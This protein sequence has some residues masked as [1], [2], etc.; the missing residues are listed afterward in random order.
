MQSHADGISYREWRAGYEIDTNMTTDGFNILLKVD[1]ETGMINGG[2]PSNCL[3]W[4][5]KMGSSYN[6]GNKGI[7]ATSRS[8]EPVELAGLLK[9]SLDGLVRLYEQG[10]YSYNKVNFKKR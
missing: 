7:P 3:T 6:S 1:E 4:M 5:D 9:A 8:G 10:Y 2:N